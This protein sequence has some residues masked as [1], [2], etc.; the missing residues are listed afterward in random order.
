MGQILEALTRQPCAEII[1][2]AFMFLSSE[3]E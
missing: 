3:A 2:N 1:L